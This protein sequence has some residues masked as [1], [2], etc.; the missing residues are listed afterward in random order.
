MMLPIKPICKKNFTRRDGTSIVFIQ[1]CQSIDRRTLLNTGIAIP[2]EYW[3]RKRLRIND[4][5]PAAYGAVADLNEQLQK[6]LRNA[7][8]IVNHAVKEKL[9]DTLNFLKKTFLPDFNPDSLVKKAQQE[10]AASPVTNLDLSFQIDDYIKSKASKV[11]PGMLKVYKN[12]KDHLDAFQA[13]RGRK[14]TFDCFDYNFYEQLVHFLTYEYVQ[15]RRKVEIKGLKTATVGKTIKQLRIFLRERMRRKIIAPI[16]LSDFKILD[17]EA[18]A[19]YLSWPEIAR[20]YHTDLTDYPHLVK[21]RDLFVLGCLTGL[22]FSDFST[23]RPEDVRQGMLHKKQGKSDHW[24]VIPLREEAEN[25]LV[26][27]FKGH[28]PD[29]CNVKFNLYIKEVAKLAGIAESIKFSHKR[30]NKDVVTVKPKYSWVTSHTCRRSFCTNEFL[31]GTPAE[32]IMKISGHK[33]L[34][35]FY[36][37]IRIT[38]EEAGRKIREI[39]EA[40]QDQNILRN[41]LKKAI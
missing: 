13:F 38:P 15:R 32:L 7:Q 40:R 12:M 16:D 31:A 6:S 9:P 25:I 36:R 29:V 10:L 17:E 1:Y 21:Y 37:Y 35:D 19:I 30:G 24:V 8:D 33:S 26:T 41:T 39:W 28:I 34:R 2:P 22:R 3:N 5:L 18:D 20:I 14:I 4:D 27:K 23:I 11:T